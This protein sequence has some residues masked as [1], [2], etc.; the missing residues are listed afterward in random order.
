MMSDLLRAL[1]LPVAAAFEDNARKLLTDAEVRAPNRKA[2][3][4]Y[5]PSLV[6]NTLHSGGFHDRGSRQIT[7]GDTT[8]VFDKGQRFAQAGWHHITHMLSGELDVLEELLT[9]QK[10]LRLGLV[11]DRFAFLEFEGHLPRKSVY[12]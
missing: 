10:L 1:G 9:S 3:W 7:L 5:L 11:P 2:S 6:R 4:M 12:G 8:Y